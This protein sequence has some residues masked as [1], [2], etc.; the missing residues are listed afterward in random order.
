LLEKMDVAALLLQ[1]AWLAHVS[2]QALITRILERRRMRVI[3]IQSVY[4]G[5]LARG[6][7]RR[8]RKRQREERREAK[9]IAW[10]SI[11]LQV[12]CQPNAFLSP[13]E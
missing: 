6:E 9:A 12:K 13:P 3:A 8:V 5:H 10:A 1:G 2:R 4:R 7:V 11:T